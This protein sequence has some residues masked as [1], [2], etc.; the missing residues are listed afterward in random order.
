MAE[1]FRDKVALITGGT[2][3]IG[4]AT[5]EKLAER[6]VKVV[7][8]GRNAKSGEAAAERICK[9]GG[10]VKYVQTDI[11]NP[12]QVRQLIETTVSTYGRLD[13]AFN[14]AGMPGLGPIGQVP[15]EVYEQIMKVN[16]GGVWYSMKHE[17]TQ[18]LQ[19]GGGVIVNTTS[20]AGGKGMAGLSAYSAAKHAVIG[21]TKSLALEYAQAGIRVNA[22]MPGPI[23][24][25]M[26]DQIGEMVPNAEEQF[27]AVTA[28]KRVGRPEEVADAVVW[29]FSEQ[30]SYVT[31][32][33]VPVDG[34][35]LAL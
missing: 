33:V 18:M 13:F 6:G 25:P 5:A 20:V 3:G 29:L 26:M 28:V 8:A 19:N 1:M 11:A 15:D 10:E 30:A 14:N 12:N 17:I 16:V 4:L 27:V 31:G 35:M 9:N 2:T 34:G 7:I 22:V 24:T 21:L 32:I 23:A